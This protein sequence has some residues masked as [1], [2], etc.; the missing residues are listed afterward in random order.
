[1]VLLAEFEHGRS[2]FRRMKLTSLL[3]LCVWQVPW[4]QKVLAYQL[5]LHIIGFERAD[6]DIL[7]LGDVIFF[8]LCLIPILIFGDTTL[9]PHYL[10]PILD[11]GDTI[12]FPHYFIPILDLGDVILFP[13][14]LIPI[15]ILSDTI[16]RA[17]EIGLPI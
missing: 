1:M 17:L 6:A 12:L 9:F 5:G 13:H 15:L 8:P 16:L 4:R 3:F 10:I 2:R 11:L 14:C 7:G